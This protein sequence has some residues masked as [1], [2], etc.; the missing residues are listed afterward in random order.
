MVRAPLG[1]GSRNVEKPQL[2]GNPSGS[3]C[4]PFESRARFPTI[5]SPIE[6]GGRLAGS[7]LVT[8]APKRFVYLIRSVNNPDRPYVGLTSNVAER[9]ADHNSGLCR[10]TASSRPWAIRVVIE[11]ADEPAAIEFEKVLEER[12]RSSLF[13]ASFCIARLEDGVFPAVLT[14]FVPGEPAFGWPYLAATTIIHGCPTPSTRMLRSTTAS[15][16]EARRKRR[17][18]S[19]LPSGPN[20]PVFPDTGSP[21]LR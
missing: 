18:L 11:F 2:A 14:P 21:G 3:F 1:D 15:A 17:R 4:V 16:Y 6:F 12:L 7:S 9:L 10:H 20:A 13:A 5:F 19:S 8:R